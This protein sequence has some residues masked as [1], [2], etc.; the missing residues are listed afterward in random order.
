M[1]AAKIIA[2]DIGG[3]CLRV[4]LKRT[5]DYFGLT[6]SGLDEV[7]E[8]YRTAF[9][10]W[11]CGRLGEDEFVAMVCQLSGRQF[12]AAEVQHGWNLMIGEDLPGAGEWVRDMLAAGYQPVFFSNTSRWHLDELRGK[13]SFAH[14][15]PDG[16]YSFDAGYEKPEA[17]IYQI[18]EKRFGRPAAYFDDR[19]DNVAAGQR[20]GWPSF[21]FTELAQARKDFPLPARSS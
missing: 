12:S 14:L 8:Q 17:A 10:E 5:L 19:A 7:P 9:Y 6:I 11:E 3:V 13:L 15:I 20:A 2:L 21:V 4:H 1:N 18:F 16:L